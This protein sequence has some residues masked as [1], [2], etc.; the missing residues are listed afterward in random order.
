MKNL[1]DIIETIFPEFA[2]R[3][4]GAAVS[5][6]GDICLSLTETDMWETYPVTLESHVWDS[7]EEVEDLL[8]KFTH[9]SGER[10]LFIMD[11]IRESFG[12][13]RLSEVTAED[14]GYT[15]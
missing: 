7:R 1:T 14:L 15:A 11:E 13:G 8:E 12:Y 5:D 4:W 10:K 6:N 2:P 9:S 3:L